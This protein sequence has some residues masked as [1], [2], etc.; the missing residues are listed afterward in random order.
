MP[1]RTPLLGRPAFALSLAL[2]SLLSLLAALPARSE[3]NVGEHSLICR[4]CSHQFAPA[5]PESPSYRKYSPDRWVDILHVAL[6]LTPDFEKRTI[7]GTM[8]MRFKAIAVPLEELRLDSVDLAILRAASSET[9]FSHQLTDKEVV[10]N[11]SPAVPAGREATVTLEYSAEPVRGLY[12]RTESMGYETTHLWTQG[13]PNES[14][15]W[16]PSFDHPVEKFTSEVTCH[17]PDGMVALS[18]GRQISAEKKPDGL[19]A[20]RWL[21]EKPHVNYLISLVAG[22]LAKIESKHRDVPLEFWTTPKELP[23]AQ[24][25]FRHTAGMMEFFEKETG[26]PYPWAKYG[27]VAV[28][29]YHWGGMENTSLTTLNHRTLFDSS[30]ENLF[31]SDGLVAHELAHQWFGDL[32]T[33][34]DWNDI[35]LNE[36]FATY[37]DWLW[38]GDFFGHDIFNQALWDAAKGILANTNETR[39][40]VWRKFGEPGEMFNYL[41]YPKGAWVLHMLRCQIGP[42][43]YRNA[44]QTYLKRHAYGSVSTDQLRAV[45]EEVTGRSF[46]RYFDQWLHGAG[47]PALDVAYAWDEKSRLAKVTVKQTQKISEEAHLFQF[48]LAVRFTTRGVAIDR[49][50]EVHEKEE[51]FFL[52]LPAAPDSVSVDPRLEVLAKINFKPPRAMT[53]LQ[54]QNNHDMLEQLRALE[55][56][57]EKPDAETVAKIAVALKTAPHYGVRIRA[58]EVLRQAR[59]PEALAALKDALTETDARVR[60][61]VVKAIG[62]WFDP[63]ALEILQTVLAAEKNPG[64]TATALRSLAPYQTPAVRALLSGHLAKPCFKERIAEG[65]LDAM[66]AQDDPANAPALFEAINGR[67][68]AGPTSTLASALDTLG[69]LQRNENSRGSARELLLAKL[70]HPR[71]S[72]RL[73]AIQA[74]GNLEDPRAIPPLESYSGASTFKPEKAAAQKAID[75]I[76]A[77]H[78]PSEELKTLRAEVSELLKAGTELKKEIETL[79]KRIESKP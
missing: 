72:I 41:A 5:K 51:T 11:F 73:A 21:Q 24:N 61:S 60:N 49:T 23:Y 43:L 37:Y 3:A 12:F 78:K 20:F 26:F 2:A 79:K 64:I 29:D 75:K 48:P 63:A 77:A 13:E 18:N 30:T 68:S 47:A 71:E 54:L 50:M 28:H 66:K 19:T 6:D 1:P 14:R 8:Q 74:L 45:F 59:T 17:L 70:Q 36:G 58:A 53:L 34:R 25:S 7:R 38:H 40:V 42:E 67:L 46:E 56:L 27:Q 57:A 15:H 32:V 9:G 62:G 22:K 10:L 16:F 69:T 52:P 39:G 35:W 31:Q 33:C 55:I 4:F 44:I 65:A 76:R